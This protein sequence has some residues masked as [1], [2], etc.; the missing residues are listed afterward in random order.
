MAT[1]ATGQQDVR[2]KETRNR[3]LTEKGVEYQKENKLKDRK[4]LLKKLNNLSSTLLSVIEHSDYDVVQNSYKDWIKTYENFLQVSDEYCLLLSSK[5]KENLSVESNEMNTY[6]NQVKMA[7]ENTLSV[8]ARSKRSAESRKSVR[9]KASSVRSDLS[10]GSSIISARLKEEQRKAEL[11][12]LLNSMKKKQTLELEKLRLKQQEEFLDLNTQL[13]VSEAKSNVIETLL[14]RESNKSM[15]DDKS[16]LPEPFPTFLKNEIAENDGSYRP[17]NPRATTFMPSDVGSVVNAEPRGLDSIVK[18]IKKPFVEIKKFDGN[19]LE[20]RRFIRQFNSR[21][22]ENTDDDDERLNFL[23]QFTIGEANRIVTGLS[24]IGSTRGYQAVLTEFE[25]RYGD[26]AI[27][28]NAL[29]KKAINWP[30]IKSDNSKGLDEFSIFLLEVENAVKDIDALK[31]LEYPDNLRKLVGKLPWS[32][33]DRWRTIVQ[34]TRSAGNTINLNTLVSFVRKESKKVNDPIFGKDMMAAA[35]DQ[36]KDKKSLRIS[37]GSRNTVAAQTGSISH[38][39]Q[40]NSFNLALK[41]P[42]IYCAGDHVLNDCKDLSNVVFEEKISFLK[43]KGLCWGCLRSG[44]QKRNCR[45]KMNCDICK[46]LHPSVLHDDSR[47]LPENPAIMTRRDQN[48]NTISDVKDGIPC[49]AIN[50]GEKKTDGFCTMAILPVRV[51]VKGRIPEVITF[52]FLDPGSS[53]SF[54]TSSLLKQIGGIGKKVRLNLDTMARS[55]MLDTQIVHCLEVRGLETEDV[56]FMPAVYTTEQMPVSPLHVPTEDDIRKWSHMSDVKLPKIDAEIG[57]LIGNNIA[58]AYTP[59]ELRIHTEAIDFDFPERIAEDKK[60]WSVEDHKFMTMMESNVKIE[61]GQYQLPMPWRDKNL[62]FPNNIRHAEKRLSNLKNK[63]LKND[64]FRHDYN[65]FMDNILAKGYAEQVPNEDLRLENGRIWYIP[66]HGVYHP[67]KPEKVRVVFDCPALYGGVSLN[68]QLLQGP[69]L[70]N[71]LVGV[72]IRFR[73]ERTAIMADI[74]SMFYRVRV[75]PDDKDCLRFLWWPDGDLNKKAIPFR[76]LVHLFGAISSP[77]CSNWALRRTATDN[78]SKYEVEVTNTVLKNFYVDDCLKSRVQDGQNPEFVMKLISLCKEGGFR[79]TKFVSN[80][81]SV[82]ESLPEEELAKSCKEL[83]SLDFGSPTERALGVHWNIEN[84]TYGFRI[85]SKHQPN[86]RRGILSTVSTVYDPLGIAAP[87]VLPVKILLQDLCREKLSWDEE[88]PEKYLKVWEKWQEGLPGLEELAISRCFKPQW[89]HGSSKSCQ[90]HHF[91]DASDVGYGTVSY[92]RLEDEN[93]Q[94]HCCF[95]FAKSRV[96][97]L[98]KMTVPRMELAAA[99]LLI[100]MNKMMLEELEYSVSNVYFWSDSTA[101][102]KY[103]ANETARYHTFVANRVNLIRDGSTI[104]QWKFVDGHLNPADY[105]SRGLSLDCIEQNSVV[106][107]HGPE[108]LWKPISEWPC[109]HGVLRSLSDDDVELKKT[110]NAVLSVS[111]DDPIKHLFNYYSSWHRL[112]RAVAWFL[113][114]KDCLLLRVSKRLSGENANAERLNTNKLSTDDLQRAELA[115]IKCV[116]ED[117]FRKELVIL[118]SNDRKLIPRGSQLYQLDPVL[119]DDIIRV[120]G[121]LRKAYFLEYE[122]RHPVVLPRCSHVSKLILLS[123]HASVGHLGKSSMLARLRE[124]YWILR[125]NQLVKDITRKCVLCKKY[126]GQVCNQKMADLP[127]ERLLPDNPPFTNTGT[128][129]FGPCEVKR[130]RCIEK[131]YGVIFT[132]LVTRAVHLEVS[133]TLDTSGCINAYRRFIA[134]RGNVRL[135]RSDNGTNFVGTNRELQR[136]IDCW[137]KDQIHD[138]LLQNNVKWIFNPPGASHFGGVW[139]RLIRSVRKILFSLMKEQGSNLND[140]N[141][142]TLFCEVESILNSRPISTLSNDPNDLQP[143]TPNHLLLLHKGST[144]PPGLFDKSDLYTRR[145]WRQVQHIANVFWKRWTSEY[146]HLL[147]IRSK[148]NTAKRNLCVGDI[149]FIVDGSIRNS[150]TLSRISEVHRDRKGFVRSASVRTAKGTIF[151]RPID[152]LCVLV[153]NEIKL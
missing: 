41:K 44:H 101:V 135:I 99:A 129:Y 35:L 45:L 10:K 46:R 71:T 117:Y 139:E 19:P 77:S 15:I 142:S 56:V 31:L 107:L 27:I 104:Q 37:Q 70:T 58:D 100:K 30:M 91:A 92:L 105:A 111:D 85:T 11:N 83:K 55:T 25:E 12:V 3:S 26:S 80:D 119:E 65:V 53:I 133:P 21:I 146:L 40:Q 102:L 114:L 79:L 121:R 88:I 47:S 98:K 153:E 13:E 75:A 132:C 32:L 126:R 152:K 17:L 109:Q 115:I 127:Q 143:L 73:Q 24:Y 64:K 131:R 97:P 124:R 62:R 96:A 128:D 60:Q 4:S 16:F 5:E 38:T 1:A 138:F 51:K 95:I 8:L 72:L 68:S 145:R 106:W 108:F 140:D 110:S 34:T 137:N 103:I 147:Q 42:C 66:H 23:E 81:R 120:G 67:K 113:R 136:N 86:T 78:V 118:R 93:G 54:C 149:V 63:L 9:S 59:F 134:R 48:Q 7:A 6:F 33:Q 130:G 28:A 61:N 52:A 49:G 144:F 76:M 50:D 151:Q 123:V 57:L 141:L 148:W 29:L 36:K 90:L 39:N 116:Q 112:K 22:A 89:F 18:H 43:R 94:V 14:D 74:E 87:Y 2:P 20:Y 125:A 69:D 82:I 122:Q 150:W 84:D